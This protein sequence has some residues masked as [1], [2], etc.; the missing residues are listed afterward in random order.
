MEYYI[1]PNTVIKYQFHILPWYIPYK[2]KIFKGL[3]RKTIGLVKL[4]KKAFGDHGF[5]GIEFVIPN[6]CLFKKNL[7]INRR[8]LNKIK[9]ARWKIGP[10]HGCYSIQIPTQGYSVLNLTQNDKFTKKHLMNN[11]KIVS[12]LG[13]GKDIVTFHSGHIKKGSSKKK[14]MQN[15]ID[16]LNSAVDYA[17][18]NNITMTL[19]NA[20][21]HDDGKTAI[22][23]THEEL[24]EILDSVKSKNL[25]ITFDWGHANVHAQYVLKNNREKKEFQY[26]QDMIKELGKNIVHAHIHYN[27]SHNPEFKDYFP[28][29]Y[30]FDEHLALT[31]IPKDEYNN[32]KRTI[33]QLMDKT[34]LKKF[35]K[36]SFEMPPRKIMNITTVFD[37]G[38]SLWDQLES[39]NIMKNMI[40]GK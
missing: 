10:F 37:L 1:D 11:L 13:N 40:K 19:E 30:Q 18:D 22:G 7:D 3:G 25:G 16:N 35:G 31:K 24:K 21:D 8:K 33:R 17:K 29:K 9:K 4:N 38:A 26:H 12:E 36:I 14:A 6:L 20:Y 15:V 28:V 39:I 27:R 32:Y 5:S 23:K 2:F 34:S